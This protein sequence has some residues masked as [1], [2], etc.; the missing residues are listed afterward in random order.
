MLEKFESGSANQI[1]DV[2]PAQFTQSPRGNIVSLKQFQ[3][4]PSRGR[5]LHRPQVV[6]VSEVDVCTK[7]QQQ[8]HLLLTVTGHSG[9]EGRVLSPTSVHI[10]TSVQQDLGAAQMFV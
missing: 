2:D 6:A 8:R 5:Q 4:L 9:V 3:G 10:R 7:V 1:P